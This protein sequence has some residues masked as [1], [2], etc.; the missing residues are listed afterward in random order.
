[1]S[2]IH[3]IKNEIDKK[4]SISNSTLLLMLENIGSVNSKLRDEVIYGGWYDLLIDNKRLTIEQ[5]RFLLNY[6]FENK[7]LFHGIDSEQSNDVFT[8]SFTSLLLVLLLEN[9]YEENWISKEEE[10]RIIKESIFYMRTE[11]DNRGFVEVKEWAHAFA[12]G[13]DLLGAISQSEYLNKNI[14]I[15]ILEIMKR[16]LIDI[17]NFL[18]GEEGRFAKATTLLVKNSKISTEELSLWI[19]ETSGELLK[20]NVRNIC[21]KNYVS[22]VLI[23]FRIENLLNNEIESKIMNYL[24]KFYLK[25]GCL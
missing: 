5:K 10:I 12:H 23:S 4:S 25:Y 20:N 13:A 22:F 15:E 2:E 9:H 1:M 6:I 18:Y 7:L 19:E 16:A 24:G 8:R 14:S 3:I 11:K 21:W 17:E